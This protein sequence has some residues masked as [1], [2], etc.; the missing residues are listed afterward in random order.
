MLS[1]W[2]LLASA[3]SMAAEQDQLAAGLVKTT[4]LTRTQSAELMK[5][6]ST[7]SEF[8]M[9]QQDTAEIINNLSA[10]FT[11]FTKL[12]TEQQV[13][14]KNNAAQ[15][16]ALGVEASISS[17]AF[18]NY[19]N[20]MGGSI[21]STEG[22]NQEMVGLANTIGKDVNAVM[23]DLN[24]AMPDLAKH[25]DGAIEVFKG[26]SA[27]AAKT[28]VSV[29]SL[30]NITKGFDTF[31]DAAGKVGKL[32]AMLGGPF[33]NSID[34]VNM[35]ETERI[36]AMKKSIEMSGRSWEAMNKHERQAIANAAGISDM[37]EAAKL[38]NAN[39]TAD[40]L[41]ADAAAGE[42]AQAT[43]EQM[44]E[45]TKEAKSAMDQLKDSINRIIIA[46]QPLI[47]VFVW[48]M[49]ILAAIIGWMPGWVVVILALALAWWKFAAA[50]K[51]GGAGATTATSGLT[52]MASGLT[53]M[54]PA[55]SAA[56]GPLALFSL[57]LI[58]FG[59]GAIAVAFAMW[60]LAQAFVTVVK[61][62]LMLLPHIGPLFLL[63]LAIGAM[64]LAGFIFLPAAI[65]IMLGFFMIAAGLFALAIAM[66][67]FGGG[68]FKALAQM[69][70]AIADMA[71]VGA[72]PISEMTAAVLKLVKAFYGMRKVAGGVAWAFMFMAYFARSAARSFAFLAMFVGLVS[73]PFTMIAE[74]VAKMAEALAGINISDTLFTLASGLN[75]VGAA[76]NRISLFRMF[77]VTVGISQLDRTLQAVAEID[78]SNVEPVKQVVDQAI[79]YST[80]VSRSRGLFGG[81]F[82]GG[83]DP[84]TKMLRALGD[85]GGAPAAAAGA[86]AGAK[87]I[88]I[89]LND[90]ELGRAVKEVFNDEMDARLK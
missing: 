25:G 11:Q 17:E 86:A 54:A 68:N 55:L 47:T 66:W 71:K 82:G 34:M 56:A 44:A 30:I 15:M 90:R 46:L 61:G 19:V 9:T 35:S 72:E 21:E 13:S 48:F 37:A 8:G 50:S 39:T 62:V 51:A 49:N 42:A 12:S 65:M 7:M 10:E 3:I 4:A 84:F 52:R 58:L 41:R 87:E 53:A 29:Q 2:T 38:F 31:E 45:R 28:G 36:I 74:A 26:L 57:A 24:A 64:A 83:A 43:Q 18:N 69:F 32:N 59:V 40:S 89:K 77:F 88:V 1:P 78:A 80:N 33:L 16:K 67:F 81:L 70:I 22:F 79:R 14:L 23:R 73:G 60:L 85:V 75:E 63:A 5:L 27:I 20:V 6:D 76:L